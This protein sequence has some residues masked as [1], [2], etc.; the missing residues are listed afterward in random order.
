[1]IKIDI[2]TLAWYKLPDEEQSMLCKAVVSEFDRLEKPLDERMQSDSRKNIENAYTGKKVIHNWFRVRNNL[3]S[4][5][6]P[7]KLGENKSSIRW[8]TIWELYNICAF[9]EY[10]NINFVYRF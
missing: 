3:Y 1:M 9:L 2:D 6:E 4:Y 5:A 8:Q 7:N 10:I